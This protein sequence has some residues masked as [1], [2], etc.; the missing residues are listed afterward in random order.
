MDRRDRRPLLGS[1]ALVVSA[2]AATRAKVG[3]GFGAAELLWEEAS[4]G[5]EALE[6]LESG[7]RE[8]SLLVVDEELVDVSSHDVEAI[9]S[10]TCPAA[11]VVWCG[12]GVD[13]PP[14]GVLRLRK[15][16]VASELGRLVAQLRARPR[17]TAVP[18]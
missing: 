18:A 8:Y 17:L 5:A 13:R 7:R 10:A 6:F 16:A 14:A 3:E 1:W 11:D 9:A 15:P 12:P 2:D 4:S